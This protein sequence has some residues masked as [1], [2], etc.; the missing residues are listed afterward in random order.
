MQGISEPSLIAFASET[1]AV[2]WLITAYLEQGKIITQLKRDMAEFNDLRALEIAE[3]RQRIAKLE[4][5]ELQEKQKDHREILLALLDSRQGKM[6]S[7][8]ARQMMHMSK[9][10]FTNLLAA[11]KDDIEVRPFRTDKR[12]KLLI[13]K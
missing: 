9:Q 13:R 10:S 2:K 6:P 3:D 4:K 8:E 7:K 11:L 5:G 12:R 1:E